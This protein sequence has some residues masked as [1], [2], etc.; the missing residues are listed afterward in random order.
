MNAATALWLSCEW[1]LELHLLAAA[2][3]F[4]QS[5]WLQ[6]PSNY[7]TV[8][9]VYIF[10]YYQ[11]LVLHAWQVKVDPTN[12]KLNRWLQESLN[13]LH[14]KMKYLIYLNDFNHGLKFSF[15]LTNNLEKFKEANGRCV[16]TTYKRAFGS[17]KCEK[18]HE[19]LGVKFY[20]IFWTCWRSVT[21]QSCLVQSRSKHRCPMRT[22]RLQVA[23]G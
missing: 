14:T 6:A 5:A 13:S 2:A 3:L 19:I 1:R 23:E 17:Q 21:T 18:Y 4:D 20:S 22:L 8:T 11:C 12:V 16:S 10:I 15:S 9:V 7:S